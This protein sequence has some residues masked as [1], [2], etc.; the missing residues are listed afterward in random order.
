MFID[1][2]MLLQA[3][4]DNLA[5][6]SRVLVRK[7]VTG[8]NLTSSGVVVTTKDGNSFSGDIAVGADGI[9]SAIRKEMWRLAEE[10]QPGYIPTSEKTGKLGRCIRRSFLG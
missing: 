8:I 9:H 4:F 3:L 10:I 1:R 2:Q 6:K 5:D 7:R